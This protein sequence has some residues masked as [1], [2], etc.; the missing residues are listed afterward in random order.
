MGELLLY[1]GVYL[2]IAI[3]IVFFIVQHYGWKD[4]EKKIKKDKK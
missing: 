4:E 2:I 1:L 3:G